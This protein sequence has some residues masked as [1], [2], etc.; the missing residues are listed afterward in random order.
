MNV[1]VAD[2]DKIVGKYELAKQESLWTRCGLNGC[3]R[4]HRFGY[5]IRAKD[6]C[7]TN[8][9]QDC[10]HREF[11]VKFEEVEAQYKRGEEV[12]ARRRAAEDVFTQARPWADELRT[13]LPAIRAAEARMNEF[14]NDFRWRTS[15]WGQL[16]KLA[17]AGGRVNLSIRDDEGKL[18]TE[19]I[20]RIDSCRVLLERPTWSSD[21]VATQLIPWLESLSST[22]ALE[23]D[24]QTFKKSEGVQS[25]L[26][27]APRFIED[28]S[29]FLSARNFALFDTMCMR[30]ICKPGSGG[31]GDAIRK[32]T[33]ESKR[34]A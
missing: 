2:L 34:A 7:E 8:C 20:G 1:H 24:Q 33:G 6:G 15:F 30:G 25:V 3:D 19:S 10:G 13:L 23:I 17:R 21:Y 14:A 16:H 27:E 4:P 12:Q 5:I 22:E 9:G 11:G 26:R 29:L 32:W 31:W 28:A 18:V